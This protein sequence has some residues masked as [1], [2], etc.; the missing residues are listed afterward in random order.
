M[1]LTISL[2]QLGHK[3]LF[4]ALQQN[5]THLNTHQLQLVTETRRSESQEWE[6]SVKW[7]ELQST[8]LEEA[9]QVAGLLPA[10]NHIMRTFQ[11]NLSQDLLRKSN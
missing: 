1:G 8:C 5:R 6:T 3:F 9:Q 2:E 11:T 4:C 10:K 7:C